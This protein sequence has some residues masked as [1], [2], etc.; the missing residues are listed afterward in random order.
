[1]EKD[2]LQFVPVAKKS[3]G[4]TTSK[5]THTV[6]IPP[7][8]GN[9]WSNYCKGKDW[10]SRRVIAKLVTWFMHAGPTI[11]DR[12]IDPP[13]EMLE[14]YAKSFESIAALMRKKINGDDDDPDYVVELRPP[15][16]PR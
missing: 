11:Q 16:K 2:F 13:P 7:E 3:G 4:A 12:I 9:A 15:R 14:E 6:E 8:I 1:M 10:K 5:T